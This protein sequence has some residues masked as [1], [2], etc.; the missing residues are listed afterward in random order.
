MARTF[1]IQTSWALMQALGE[2]MEIDSVKRF[3]SAI[4]AEEDGQYILDALER[5]GFIGARGDY[6]ATLEVKSYPMKDSKPPRIG[7]GWLIKF[8]GN[9][10]W[11]GG[12]SS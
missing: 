12:K 4:E 2:K 9:E 1:V 5:H 10:D 7:F 3:D 11:R 8:I 6:Q